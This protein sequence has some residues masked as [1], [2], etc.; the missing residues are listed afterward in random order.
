[1]AALDWA[2]K[3]TDLNT[4]RQST[5]AAEEAIADDLI[6]QLTEIGTPY[7]AAWTPAADT[8]KAEDEAAFGIYFADWDT[9]TEK[10][11]DQT[12]KVLHFTEDQYS[13]LSRSP[14]IAW[15]SDPSTFATNKGL[16]TSKL[17]TYITKA[18]TTEFA[19]SDVSG[20][21]NVLR[22]FRTKFVTA[23]DSRPV[24]TYTGS[25]GE[26]RTVT[27]PAYGAITLAKTEELL[28][29]L[30]DEADRLIAD[31]AFVP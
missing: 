12:I 14:D 9:E 19:V 2:L 21:P 27:I 3:V 25:Y 6:D 22:Y 31:I 13:D 26:D 23:Y 17:G 7:D 18:A 28:Q 8:Q 16:I 24:L 30:M 29:A 15:S 11:H 10:V 1:M 20:L 4:A 5:D